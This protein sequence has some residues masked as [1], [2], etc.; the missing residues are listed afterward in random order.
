MTCLLTGARDFH[1]VRDCSLPKTKTIEKKNKRH[2]DEWTER[3]STVIDHS[4]P[5]SSHIKENL[6]LTKSLNRNLLL[7]FKDEYSSAPSTLARSNPQSCAICRSSEASIS[8]AAVAA[9]AQS[10]HHHAAS[11]RHRSGYASVGTS[12]RMDS[13]QH[14]SKSKKSPPPQPPPVPNRRPFQHVEKTCS[15]VMAL[16]FLLFN[17]IY[18]PWLLGDADFDY[19]KFT[20]TQQQQIKL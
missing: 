7:F 10:S 11:L 17:A 6:S 5:L 1:L 8:A 3:D 18:W 14:H 2:L 13:L 12:T 19:A 9:A 16:L 20:A 4:A 15:F